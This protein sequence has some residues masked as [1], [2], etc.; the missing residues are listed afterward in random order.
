[1]HQRDR[2]NHAFSMAEQDQ[3]CQEQAPQRHKLG[4]GVMGDRKRA[5]EV[6]IEET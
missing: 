6:A 5:T 4:E 1:M 2:I 3:H